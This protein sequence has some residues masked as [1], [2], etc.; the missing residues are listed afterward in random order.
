MRRCRLTACRHHLPAP[1]TVEGLRERLGARL[2][3]LRLSRNQTQANLARQA[4]VSVSSVKRL[5]AGETTS[6]DN[7]LRVLVALGVGDRLLGCLPDPT[8]R[9]VE[10]V[11]LG[12]RERRRA[13]A[14]PE[15]VPASSWAWG[16]EQD[17]ARP[18][19]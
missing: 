5:E 13:R 2:A 11:A 12:G 14:T 17:T 19:R 9:P 3:Q 7:H 4:G 6:L 16:S 18:R 10:R 15:P 8:V 1:T